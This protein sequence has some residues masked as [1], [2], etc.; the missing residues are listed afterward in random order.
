MFSAR[1][2]PATGTDALARLGWHDFEHL[3]AEHYRDQ[4]WRVEYHAP[5][6]SLKHL[7]SSLDLRLHRGNET[8][9]VQCKHWDTVEVQLA[10]VNELLSTMLNEAATRCVLVTRGRFSAEARAVPR[11]QP[12]L[13]LVDGDVLRVMLKLPGHL[14]T[15]AP[16]M[17]LPSVAARK[18]ASAG[19]ASG[20]PNARLLPILL[21][22]VIAAL[23][24]IF[25]WRMMTPRHDAAMSSAPTDE[26][27][28]ATPPP[29]VQ[30]I[31]P[32]VQPAP[33]V[34]PA[35]APLSRELAERERLREAASSGSTR[36]AH[37]QADDAIKVM[38]RNTREVG[39]AD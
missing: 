34:A 28:A 1:Q 12:R 2:T 21:F 8:V 18:G 11:R 16:S 13:Q 17:A 4:G 38:E 33:P 3:L 35:E 29:P 37:R 24:A 25:V 36:D 14:D 7:G 32:P 39:N 6:A 26:A 23:L 19:R 10:E 9:I 15:S 5:P 22:V 27:A 20:E 30:A 31:S